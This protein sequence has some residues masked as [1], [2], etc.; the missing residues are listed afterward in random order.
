MGKID[1][2]LVNLAIERGD[3]ALVAKYR[4]KILDHIIAI[5]YKYLSV[6][7]TRQ[8][9]VVSTI[10]EYDSY[11]KDKKM[12]WLPLYD[13]LL[14]ILDEYMER[15]HLI[16]YKSAKEIR[17]GDAILYG[18]KNENK[19]VW[20]IESINEGKM[21]MV[22]RYRLEGRTKYIVEYETVDFDSKKFHFGIHCNHKP[23]QIFF[24]F[25]N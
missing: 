16:R 7:G 25:Y 10:K 22:R 11:K 19:F 18:A 14:G 15:F 23:K 13:Y 9:L 6:G 12:K 24:L 2:K 8:E 5:S 3:E 17:V 20:R 21:G 1:Y 4:G